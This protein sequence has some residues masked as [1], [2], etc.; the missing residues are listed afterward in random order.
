M[1]T[2]YTEHA[3]TAPAARQERTN[4]AAW[5]AFLAAGIGSFSTGLVI[6]LNETGIFAVPALYAPA[7]GVSGR[8]SLAIA[9]WLMAWVLLHFRWKDREV[10]F[11]WVPV[12]T[13]VLVLLGI[14]GPFPPFWSAL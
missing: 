12:G 4:G 9:I 1:A 2:T 6:I 14:L 10:P 8:T 7:G 11:R 5:A 13:I 3:A